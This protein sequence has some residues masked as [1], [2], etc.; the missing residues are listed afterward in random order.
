M[1]TIL[2]V[3]LFSSLAHAD[4]ILSPGESKVIP[5][6][7]ASTR[8]ACVDSSSTTYQP[9]SGNYD[10]EVAFFWQ[11]N[12]QSLAGAMF[13]TGRISEDQ[14]RCRSAERGRSPVKSYGRKSSV[15][16][17]GRC[18]NL[19]LDGQGSPTW[20]TLDACTAASQLVSR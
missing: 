6:S 1:K 18:V 2:T 9:S 5:A 8:V 7:R 4:L 14:F 15:S 17:N 10:S 11:T 20:S 19:G 12:C 13:L 3:L 16:I